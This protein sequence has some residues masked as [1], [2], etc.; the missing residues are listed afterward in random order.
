MRTLVTGGTGL[1]GACIVAGL[2]EDG[3]DVRLLVRRPEQVAT[4][5][6]PY[7]V[8]ADRVEV[9]VGDVRHGDAVAAAIDG[10]EAVVHAAAVFSIDTRRTQEVLSTNERAAELVLGQACAA[11]LDPV[12][13]ISST[14]ALTRFD[15]SGPDLPLGDISSPYS[16]SKIASEIVARRLQDEGR[17]VVC[18]YPGAVLG[19]HDPYRGVQSEMLRWQARGTFPLYPRGGL[20]VVDVRTVAAVVRAVLEPGRGPRRYVVPGTHVDARMHYRTLAAVQG[21]RRPCVTAPG[22]VLLPMTRL[23]DVLQR[24]LP[25]RLHVPTDPEGV[26]MLVRD[27]HLDDGP[28][29][30]ELGVQPVPFEQSIRDTVAWLVESGRL[31]ARYGPKSPQGASGVQR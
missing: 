8:S 17:P 6:A 3:H 2:L 28:A 10:C 16:R 14:V 13:H 7:G 5:L 30:T 12:V 25:G 22:R 29:R 11:G 9:V 21:R 19:P 23:L 27:T 15:G 1:V 4:S 18:V 31:P 26:E 20:H 24:R